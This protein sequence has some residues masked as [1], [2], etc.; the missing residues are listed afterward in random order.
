VPPA[1]V[2]LAVVLHVELHSSLAHAVDGHLRTQKGQ[3]P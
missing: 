2:N 1:V 3:Q